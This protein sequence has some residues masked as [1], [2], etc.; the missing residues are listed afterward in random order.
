MNYKQKLFCETYLSNGFNCRQAYKDVYHNEK[1]DPSYCYRL[2]QK[3]EVKEYIE[4]RRQEIYEARQ[5][6]AERV[7][8]AIADIAFGDV[9]PED[10]ITY[11][12]KLK[13]LELL[14]KNLNLQ[15]IKTENKD[16][17]EVQLVEDSDE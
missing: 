2:I 7:M 9:S 1:K 16:T 5:I 4:Q 15:T 14:S 3:P 10:A 11:T 17:I 12:S 13:A 8:L 6:D